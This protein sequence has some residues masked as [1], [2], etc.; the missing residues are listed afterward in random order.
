MVFAFEPIQMKNNKRN[1]ESQ[2]K[3]N[4]NFTLEELYEITDGI[5]FELKTCQLSTGRRNELIGELIGATQELVKNNCK[6]FIRMS[7]ADELEVDELYYTA[8]GIALWKAIQD[9][10]LETGT[11]FLTYWHI[12]MKGY[13][14][15]EFRK[16][17]CVTTKFQKDFYSTDMVVD[18]NGGTLLSYEKSED[19]AEAVCT[20][21]TL[22]ELID[23]FER[24]D[25]L[26]KVIRCELIGTKSIKTQA[27][28]HV[29]GASTYGDRERKQVQR[30]K[31]RFAKFLIDNGFEY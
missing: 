7:R 15:N 27:L 2:M 5:I 1:E 20:T 14:K 4:F 6:R 28:L 30:A 19:F 31:K 11:H 18:N 3:T 17:T 23:K 13:F 25:A 22:E 8:T 24:V 29:L 16:A 26:G 9:F 12:V 10:D 21:L